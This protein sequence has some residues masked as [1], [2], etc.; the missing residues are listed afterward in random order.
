MKL[1]DW[2]TAAVA[3]AYIGAKVYAY[4]RKDAKDEKRKEHLCEDVEANARKITDRIE[5]QEKTI[6]GTPNSTAGLSMLTIARVS[7]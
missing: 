7:N 1:D 6:A 5:V 4:L 2:E 3:I